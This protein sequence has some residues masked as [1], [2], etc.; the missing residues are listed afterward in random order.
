MEVR[1]LASG[2]QGNCLAVGS[3]RGAGI[4]V[5]C[6]I[7]C[8]A[9]ERHARTCDLDLARISA[10][11]FTHDHS[12]HIAGLA[13]FHKRHPEV[14]LY[15]NSDTA[16]AIMARTGV[17][18]GWTIFDTFSPFPLAD[19][20]VTPF[21]LSHD[22]AH[23]VGFLVEESDFSAPQQDAPAL[24]VG[25]DT[26]VVTQEM[27][28]AF[29]RAD[30]AVLESNYDSVLLETSDRDWTL[31]RRISGRSG[32]LS[33]DDAADLVRAANPPRL[34]TLLLAH[35]SRQCNAPDIALGRMR[36][37]LAACGRGDVALAALDQ[38]TPSACF[39]V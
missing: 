3:A 32:H 36:Q 16:E 25:T 18:E 31:K 5:D 6:G 28:A 14:A 11:L 37:A 8:R 17:E 38:D 13:T 12:D 7:S 24:F 2:S 1:V 10:V 15:A 35:I 21:P 20:T 30:C 23:P 26:G 4:L 29:C 27:R 33:N 19:F 22:A 34:K 39:T 9:L